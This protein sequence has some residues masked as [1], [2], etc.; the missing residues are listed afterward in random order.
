MEIGMINNPRYP[1]RVTIVRLVPGKG[2]EDNPFA[3]DDA[4]V[5]D[6]EVVLYDGKG[7]SF[8]DTTTTG[9]KNVDENKRKASIP[10]RF[11]DWKAGGFP[12]DGDTIRVRVGN[13]SEEGMV[14]DCEGDNNRTVVYWSLRRV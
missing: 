12:L 4:L 9:D 2:D 3:D 7:R 10:M 13:H 6:E 8:T 5:N 11:D 1:H 14:K